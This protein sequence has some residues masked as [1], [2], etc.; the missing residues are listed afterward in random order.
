MCN[1]VS[2]LNTFHVKVRLQTHRQTV[3]YSDNQ[4]VRQSD[5]R[6][7]PQGGGGDCYGGCGGAGVV[8][9]GP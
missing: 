9:H 1:T 2:V 4:A 7:A 8:I 5:S 3:K 6:V